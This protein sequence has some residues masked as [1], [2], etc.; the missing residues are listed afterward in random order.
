[1]RAVNSVGAGA[2]SASGQGSPTAQ[3]RIRYTLEI[4]WDNDGN[5]ANARSDIYGSLIPGTL[6]CFRGRS[7]GSQVVAQVVAGRMSFQ[8]TDPDRVFDAG[9]PNSPLAGK[10]AG[11]Q[12]IR[13]S[14]SNPGVGLTATTIWQGYVDEPTVRRSRTE[15]SSVQMRALGVMSRLS[16][17]VVS[18]PPYTSIETAAAAGHVA[19]AAGLPAGTHRFT[20]PGATNQ[21]EYEMARWWVQRADALSALRDLEDTER[22]TLFEDRQGKL[23]L[24]SRASRITGQ[25]RTPAIDITDDGTGDVGIL[26]AP[27]TSYSPR[28]VAN[29]VEVTVRSFV[30]GTETVLWELAGEIT[31]P[32]GE[33]V[34]LVATYPGP[35]APLGHAGVSS[36]EALSGGSD[37]SDAGTDYVTQSGLAVTSTSVGDRLRITLSNSSGSDIDIDELQARGTPLVE[38]DQAT[39]R[40]TDDDSIEAFLER[41]YPRPSK[42]LASLNDAIDWGEWIINVHAFPFGNPEVKWSAH[43]DPARAAGLDINRRITVGIDGDSQDYFIEGIGHKLLRDGEHVVTYVG[44]STKV[45]GSVIVL[46]SGPGLDE[47]TLG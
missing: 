5:F 43:D 24:R 10:L 21:G 44:S 12:R 20:D 36:W 26:G 31:V 15:F 6:E 11:G 45:A 22:G 37:Y 29:V 4:D 38:S 3:D 28:D 7:Y 14:M 41:S 47:G 18:V 39:L 8:L 19:D 1:M 13:W 35:S 33:S 42:F 23:S 30:A 2:W 16:G 17:V 46:D 34:T 9:N 32:D 27:R 40:F 25:S